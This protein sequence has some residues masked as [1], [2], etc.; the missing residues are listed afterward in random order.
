[1]AFLI[2]SLADC[3]DKAEESVQVNYDVWRSDDDAHEF[4]QC[5]D[6]TFDMVR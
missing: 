2:V 4:H 1:M 5:M 3:N 6:A